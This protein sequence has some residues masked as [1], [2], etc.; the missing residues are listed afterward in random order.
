ME[1]YKVVQEYPIQ[2]S[3]YVSCLETTKQ[4]ELNSKTTKNQKKLRKI[5]KDSKKS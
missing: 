1:K 3:N 4:Q 2:M 5:K